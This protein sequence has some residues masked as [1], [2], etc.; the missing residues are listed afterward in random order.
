VDLVVEL[1]ACI[2]V[3]GVSNNK[4]LQMKSK[5]RSKR[6]VVVA[7]C[8]NNCLEATMPLVEGKKKRGIEAQW[9]SL[10]CRAPMDVEAIAL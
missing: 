8:Q 6:R 7:F 3:E 9:P 1:C 10:I 2:S 4:V 5:S